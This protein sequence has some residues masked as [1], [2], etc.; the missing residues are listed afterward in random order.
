MFFYIFTVFF[1][2]FAEVSVLTIFLDWLAVW[3]QIIRV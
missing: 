3:G 1:R 2:G